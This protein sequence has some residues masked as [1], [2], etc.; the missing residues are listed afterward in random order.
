[1]AT[2]KDYI[3]LIRWSCIVDSFNSH[4]F[5]RIIVLYLLAQNVTPWVAVSIP[6]VLEFARLISRG[7]NPI[8]K[9][10]LKVDYKKYHIFHLIVFLVLGI[11]ISQCR[12]VYTIYF[13][14]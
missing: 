11:I 7:F 12:S 5:I 10:A 8:V 9:F 14:T 6:I 3:N 1:M 4:Y 2:K 13:F